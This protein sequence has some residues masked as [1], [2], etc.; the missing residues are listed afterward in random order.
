[1]TSHKTCNTVWEAKI[2]QK[3]FSNDLVSVCANISHGRQRPV[4]ADEMANVVKENS[5][6]D[7][8]GVAF[9]LR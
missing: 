1:M 6:N 3:L 7:L 8:V 2:F 4:E 9:F 5:Q